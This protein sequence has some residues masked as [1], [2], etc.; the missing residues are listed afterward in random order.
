MAQ[1]LFPLDSIMS[2][3]VVIVTGGADGFGAAIADRFSKEK[4]QVILLDL[5]REK[6]ECKSLQDPQLYYV[7][8]DVTTRETWEHVLEVAIARYGRIDVVVNNAGA[9]HDQQE[10]SL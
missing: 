2:S 3:R 4:F 8:G 1:T 6:G 7:Y 9:F 10:Y 5:N